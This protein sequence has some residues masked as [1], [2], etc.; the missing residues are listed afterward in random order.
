MERRAQFLLVAVFLLLSLASVVWFVRWI[1]PGQEQAVDQ[2]TVQFE[3]SVSGLSVGSVVRYLG[4]PVGRV[5]DI[6]LSPQSPGRVDVEIGLDQALPDSSALVGLLEPQGITGLALIELRDRDPRTAPIEVAPGLIPGQPSVFSAVSGAATRVA[7]QTEAVLMR[8]NALL[9]EQVIEDFAATA[10]QLRVLAG[11]LALATEDVHVLVATL[12]RVSAQLDSA[13]PEY[14]ALGRRVEA[15]LIPT[16]VD[17][18]RSLQATSDS[19]AATLGDNRE[20][21]KQLLEQDLPSLIRLGDEFALTLE[22]LHRLLGNI[23]NQPGALF[24]G[25]PVTEVEIPRD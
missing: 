14:H 7:G 21:V 24:Y 8:V 3:G 18:G 9:T 19:L 12:G 13:L 10:S 11:N 4:V 1:A 20:E 6:G 15:E 17:T 23:N 16:M 25:K 2:R 22:E 5:L